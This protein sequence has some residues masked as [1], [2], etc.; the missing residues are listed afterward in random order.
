MASLNDF[1]IQKPRPALQ[2]RGR[3]RLLKG[4][5]Q[6]LPSRTGPPRTVGPFANSTCENVKLNNDDRLKYA[7]KINRHHQRAEGRRS[8][9]PSFSAQ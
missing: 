7:E 3:H 9:H 8:N 1:V 4:K 5:A 2:D 6:H